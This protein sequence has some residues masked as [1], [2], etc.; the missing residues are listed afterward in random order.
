MQVENCRIRKIRPQ[1]RDGH[2]AVV[3]GNQ[4]VI[5]GG[6]RHRLSFNDMFECDLASMIAKTDSTNHNHS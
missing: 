1:P 5:L 6:D 4:L 3:V 2:A